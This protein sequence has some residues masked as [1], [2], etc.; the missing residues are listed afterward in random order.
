VRETVKP[1]PRDYFDPHAS[2][3][4][5]AG[6]VYR[7][8]RAMAPWAVGVVVAWSRSHC[9]G[10]TG[11]LHNRPGQLMGNRPIQGGFR[12]SGII[13]DPHGAVFPQSLSFGVPCR[14]GPLQFR[15]ELAPIPPILL[16]CRKESGEH[17]PLRWLVPLSPGGIPRCLRVWNG[18]CR[19]WSTRR[20]TV[21]PTMN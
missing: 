15:R 2:S 18:S 16:S 3:L 1:N 19:A 5:R 20:A 11:R 9:E 12:R 13:P 21:G 6:P 14:A 8:I 7:G 4:Q 17:E 10:I